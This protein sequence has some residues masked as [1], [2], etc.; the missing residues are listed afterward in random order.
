[1]EL[2]IRESFD[3]SLLMHELAVRIWELE[4]LMS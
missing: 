3:R 4:N 2:K 1:M